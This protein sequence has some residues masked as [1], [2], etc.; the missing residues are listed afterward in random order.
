MLPFQWS[1]QGDDDRVF[2][3]QVGLRNI[4]RTDMSSWEHVTCPEDSAEKNDLY[5]ERNYFFDFVHNALYDTGRED[6]LLWHFERK[7][8]RSGR[9][10]YVIDCGSVVYELKVKAINCSLTY[11]SGSSFLVASRMET[12]TSERSSSSGL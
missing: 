6:T 4:H 2:S 10:S 5:N 12:Y 8:T 1:I 3:E 11:L 9:V 7:E